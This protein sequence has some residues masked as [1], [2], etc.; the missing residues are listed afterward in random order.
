MQALHGSNVT[1]LESFAILNIEE[2][3]RNE[4]NINLFTKFLIRQNNL[5][6][7]LIVGGK[8]FS[9]EATKK[10]LKTIREAPFIN[11]LKV[12]YLKKLIWEDT[13]NCKLLIEFIIKAPEL[14]EVNIQ[15]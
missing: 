8:M 7:F 10:L 13:E 12:L 6:N 14:L 11:K 3:W 4:N 2:C 5:E 1:T 15:K 9:N